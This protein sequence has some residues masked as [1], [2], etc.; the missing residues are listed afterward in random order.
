MEQN[1]SVCDETI[2]SS[3]VSPND[4]GPLCLNCT[5]KPFEEQ[6]TTFRTPCI[7]KF[8]RDYWTEERVLAVKQERQAE[9]ELLSI[10]HNQH[11][12][13]C[14][15]CQSFMMDKL[16]T[17]FS[18]YTCCKCD[19]AWCYHCWLYYQPYECKGCADNHGYW[20]PNLE[21]PFF[22]NQPKTIT[23]VVYDDVLYQVVL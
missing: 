11:S 15:N 2:M 17:E 1:C 13:K 5:F 21:A 20:R 8:L 19:G 9:D 7:Y 16:T 23:S 18:R 12:L 6:E 22:T 4:G 14:T 10:T 3:Y